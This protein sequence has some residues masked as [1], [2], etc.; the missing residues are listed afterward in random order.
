M[1][2]CVII[3]SY[4]VA[5]TIGKLTKALLK[6]NIFVLVVNDG[7]I[8]STE[9]KAKQAGA[10]VLTNTKNLGKGQSLRRG[11]KYALEK[12]YQIIITMD[13]D[14]QHA[15]EDI[16]KFIECA[17][18]PE[19]KLIIGNRMLNPKNMPFVRRLTNI[20]MSWLLSK[21][22]HQ[23]IPDSQCGYRLLKREVL[24]NIELSVSKFEI[25]SEILVSASRKGFKIY[26]VP[27]QTIYKGQSSMI[28]PLR[29][30]YRFFKFLLQRA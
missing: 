3:P 4:N 20:F 8:D 14:G 19:K 11:F 16:D 29:D 15:V 9:T 22:C 7:S 30:T 12:D 13:G 5:D 17:K 27:I 18:D 25:E 28:H 21:I 26:S 23:Y 2:I 6:K 24:E 10:F 1:K